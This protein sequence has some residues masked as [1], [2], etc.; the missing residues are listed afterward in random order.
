M[1]NKQF[2]YIAGTGRTG[3]HWVKHLLD[4]STES[5][6]VATF[7]DNFP[8]RA[9]TSARRTPAAFFNNYSLNLMLGNQGALTY[10]EC[11]PAL[12][13]HIGLTYG[14]RDALSVI[15]G[16]LF[17]LPPQGLLMVR[18]PFAYAESMKARGYGWNWWGYARAREV[19]N[20]GEGF[21]HRPVVEQFAVAWKLKNEFYHSLTRAGASVLKFERLFDYRVTKERFIERVES[22]FD[23]FGIE[24]IRDSA[25][26]W[27]LRDQRSAGKAKGAVTLTA[28]EKKAIKR[29]CGDM[30]ET[31]E[32]A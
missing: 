13:E 9:K 8:K 7:H 15:P 3:S 27:R 28:A 2:C 5:G 17:A 29:I 30:M 32:Y 1:L 24:P 21:P 6:K 25:F 16:G 10:V 23:T 19:Y 18:H 12:L 4:A 22:I 26:W 11:N 20:I 14:I 31:F